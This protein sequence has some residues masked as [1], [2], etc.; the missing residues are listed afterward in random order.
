MATDSNI[1]WC[2]HT[3]NPVRGCTKISPGCANCY[4]EA[5]SGRNPAVLG[6][7]GPNGKRAFA[8][9]SYWK[10]LAKWNRAA[11]KAGE[12]HRVF[13]ASLADVFEGEGGAVRRDYIPM[14][15]RLVQE[16][17]DL[18]HL[19]F[20]VLTK[21][22]QNMVSWAREAVFGWP[23][24]W[25]A[26]TSVENQE[27][28]DERIPHLLH[29]DANVRFLSMEPL[30]GEV[31]LFAIPDAMV[32]NYGQVC[33]SGAGM[34][35][36]GGQEERKPGLIDWV[37]V[38]GESGRRARPMHPEWVRNI[39]GQCTDAGVPFLFKQ[40][41]RWASKYAGQPRV[42]GV[43]HGFGKLGHHKMW[44]VGKKVAGRILDGRT[45]DEFP[46]EVCATCKGHRYVGYPPDN[47]DDCPDCSKPERKPEVAL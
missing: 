8:A 14:L 19:R 5:M 16:T 7:W 42:E 15:H 10:N 35:G 27:A 38:G 46:G 13:V 17:K 1:E 44:P 9:E 2:H 3:F 11:E 20:L 22:P 23:W 45:W 39:R 18:K 4:A 40:H 37:I 43:V 32:I 31:D 41:G 29:V 25:W 30:L 33:C 21:R 34:C 28:A 47:Y 26:G 6:E 36:C 24:N 12:V